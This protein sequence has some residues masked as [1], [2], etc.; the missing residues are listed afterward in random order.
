MNHNDVELIQHILEGQ[1]FEEAMK[2]KDGDFF[3]FR[4]KELIRDL[5]FSPNGDMLAVTTLGKT[6]LFECE[7]QTRIDEMKVSK[8]SALAFLPDDTVLVT[9]RLFNGKIEL[10]DLTT[11]DKFSTLDGHT[12]GVEQLVFSPDGKTLASIGSEGTILIW[13]WD[14]IRKSTSGS[15][16]N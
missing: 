11:G 13:D 15:E 12:N 10:W 14:E 16:E 8:S 6:R 7:K 4:T 3:N 2:K 9:A 1:W 5:V